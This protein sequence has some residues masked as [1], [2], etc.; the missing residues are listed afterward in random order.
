MKKIAVFLLVA[1]MATP[2]LARTHSASSSHDV[3]QWTN[4]LFNEADADHN[5]KLSR[6]EYLD[7][8]GKVFDKMDANENGEI[9]KKQVLAYKTEEMQGRKHASLKKS[10]DKDKSAKAEETTSQEE[11]EHMAS[12]DDSD[13]E[14]QDNS[15]HDSGN[16]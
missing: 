15:A 2:A 4:H 11:N 13:R 1:S 16:M 3:N 9:T 14:A 7:Y 5:G 10:R 8:A 6:D 12:N